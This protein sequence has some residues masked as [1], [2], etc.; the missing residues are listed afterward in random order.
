M[1]AILETKNR[2][3]LNLNN[4]DY[5]AFNEL[6]WCCYQLKEFLEAATWYKKASYS[7]DIYISSEAMNS[8]GDIYM[9][10]EFSGANEQVAISWYRK[11]ALKGHGC[12]QVSLGYYYKEKKDYASALFWYMKAAMHGEP[13]LGAWYEIGM[14]HQCLHNRDEARHCF[15]QVAEYGDSESAFQL[16]NYM[17]NDEIVEKM[18]IYEN[19][20]NNEEHRGSMIKLAQM[21]E[22]GRGEDNCVLERNID[23]AIYWY[24]KA[25][26]LKNEIYAKRH[27]AEVLR[28]EKHDYSEAERLI[29]LANQIENNADKASASK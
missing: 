24:K 28:R 11:A 29:R 25:A 17:G 2:L 18:Q 5:S 12:A 13:E 7:E 19:L 23:E 15:E 20:A 3:L 4:R 26:N 16:A 14:I 21:Y 10:N 1:N 9:S 27:L 8:L 6:G 22:L